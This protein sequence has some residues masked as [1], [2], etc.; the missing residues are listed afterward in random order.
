MNKIYCFVCKKAIPQW[1]VGYT[2][3]ISTVLLCKICIT[4]SSYNSYHRLITFNKFMND[5]YAVQIICRDIKYIYY[6]TKTHI[7]RQS[8]PLP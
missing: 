5:Q 7:V 8:I 1:L 2:N 4:C 6:A 3:D